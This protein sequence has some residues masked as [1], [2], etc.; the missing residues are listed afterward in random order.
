MSLCEASSITPA[1]YHR[2][3]VVQSDYTAQDSSYTPM[4]AEANE[5]IL[6][7]SKLYRLL[8]LKTYWEG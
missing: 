4:T 8:K 1:H 3:V 2:F 5:E 7:L 6:Q